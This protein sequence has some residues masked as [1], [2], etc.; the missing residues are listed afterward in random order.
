MAIKFN[1]LDKWAR[2]AVGSVLQLPGEKLRRVRVE[3]NCPAAT[4]VDVVEHDR[5]A[6]VTFLAVVEGHE[7][8][9]FIAQ[10]LVELV[11]TSDDDVW[12]FTPDGDL[13]ATEIPEAT[14]FTK[15]ASRR[16]RNPELELLMFKQQ[17][18]IERRMS[19]I[20]AEFDARI[21]EAGVRHD[22]S[23]GEVDDDEDGATD[24]S[25]SGASPAQ[26]PVGDTEQPAT[27]T[28]ASG[29]AGTGVAAGSTVA[30]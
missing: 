29:G 25:G 16:A 4:R 11:F 28:V 13:V 12:Y 2:L 6:K 27:G 18:N 10:N 7:T 1:N 21:A 30:K 8:I 3:L 14:S 23:T 17:Q 5:E 20:Q 24:A 15:I 9:E 22:P 19:A 26:P